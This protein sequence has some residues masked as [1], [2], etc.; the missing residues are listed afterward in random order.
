MNNFL[1]YSSICMKFAPNSSVLE[2]LSVWL[3]FTISDP[4]PLM[5]KS[6]IFAKQFSNNDSLPEKVTISESV[7]SDLSFASF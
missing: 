3:G 7:S 2:I 5:E 6:Q 1:V 4:F